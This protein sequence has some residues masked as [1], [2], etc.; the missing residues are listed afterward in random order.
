VARSR[1]TNNTD[2]HKIASAPRMP[3]TMKNERDGFI[4]VSASAHET[5]KRGQF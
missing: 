3:A 5:G 4:A 2:I 1:E